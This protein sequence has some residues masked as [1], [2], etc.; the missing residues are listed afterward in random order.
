MSMPD[1][2]VNSTMD[3]SH[4]TVPQSAIEAIQAMFQGKM[5]ATILRHTFRTETT[6]GAP[7]IDQHLRVNCL[8][9][10]S[11]TIT[12]FGLTYFVTKEELINVLIQLFA[13]LINKHHL[14]LGLHH[15]IL[16]DVPSEMTSASF[17]RPLAWI[18]RLFFL[19]SQRSTF[20]EKRP[21]LCGA[22]AA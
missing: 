2:T 17:Q 13:V 9:R 3:T 15:I 12:H 5:N 6:G 11:S 7:A 10:D 21:S 22:V 20:N 4:N 8:N 1:S 14:K 16:M 19:S 18:S